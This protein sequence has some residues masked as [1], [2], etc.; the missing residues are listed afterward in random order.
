M[1]NRIEN[2]TI[3]ALLLWSALFIFSCKNDG[4]KSDA[5][6]IRP[7]LIADSLTTTRY[8]HGKMDYQFKTPLLTRYEGKSNGK[9]TVYVIFDKGIYI[10]TYDTLGNVESWLTAKYAINYEKEERWEIRDS[11]VGQD[12]SGKTVYTDLL[13]WNNK[14]KLIHSTEKTIVIDGQESVVGLN[15][16]ESKEDLS[17]IEFYNSKGRILV[18]TMKTETQPVDTLKTEGIESDSLAN[19]SKI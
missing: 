10:E 11:V 7:T 2:R 9:D 15:G 19:I 8:Q 14:T 5:D 17:N 3:L 1:V 18:D 6:A 4:A 16:F 13:F 12:K